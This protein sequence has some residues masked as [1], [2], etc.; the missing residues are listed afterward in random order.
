M[1]REALGKRLALEKVSAHMPGHK[2]KPLHQTNWFTLDTTEIS[3][4]DN[5]YAPSGILKTA[6]VKAA[7]IFGARETH[8]L[9]NGS[10]VGMLSAIMGACNRGESLIIGRDCHKSVYNAIA[11]H[12]LSEVVALPLIGQTGQMLGY[13][14]DTILELLEANPNIRV[15]VLTSPTYYGYVTQMQTIA[16]IL[17]QRQ[18]TLIVD[19]AHGAHLNFGNLCQY[20]ALKMGA[21]VVIQSAHKTLPAMTQTGLLHFSKTCDPTV[22][23]RVKSY[24]KKLQTTSPSYVLMASIDDSIDYMTKHSADQDLFCTVIKGYRRDRL[25]SWLSG[26][27][28]PQDPLK[29]WLATEAN[30]YTGYEVLEHLEQYGIVP[31]YAH[32]QGVLC[33]LS[34]MNTEDD[35]AMIADA[36]DQL[37]IKAGLEHLVSFSFAKAS[38]HLT[39]DQVDGCQQELVPLSESIG[40]ICA[41]QITPYP[42]GVPLLMPGELIEEPHILLLETILPKH[43]VAGLSEGDNALSDQV[44]LTEGHN[45]LDDSHGKATHQ[46][47]VLC[48]I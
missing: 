13:S 27:D 38:R 48:V 4:T 10:T 32:H 20:S 42:P 22:M 41:Q 17:N 37:E 44:H 9:V 6:M 21:H 46:W 14:P 47:Y 1:L 3:G 45:E 19:E 33:Y 29:L 31:E 36:L 43:F 18:G 24:L 23:T 40:R 34:L 15:V 2:Y 28:G 30:G 12:G 26:D 16:A 11:I 35:L 25:R 5:L 7:E 8:F 39:F